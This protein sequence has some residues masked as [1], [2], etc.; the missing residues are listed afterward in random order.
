[1]TAL[2]AS[3]RRLLMWAVPIGVLAVVLATEL[4]WGRDAQRAPPPETPQ[5]PAPVSVG[6]LP[7]YAIAGG[8]AALSTTSEHTLFNPTRRPAPPAVATAS[9]GP[10]QM[11]RGQFI[12]TGTAVYGNTAVAYLKEAAGGKPRSVHKGDTINGMLVAQVD[13][14]GV[15]FTKGGE[16]EDLPLKIAA[17]PKTT[18][19]PAATTATPR[20]PGGG[21]NPVNA[22]G[23]QRQGAQQPNPA[24]GT[25]PGSLG[26]RRR[27]ARAAEAERQRAEPA[28]DAAAQQGN[29]PAAQQPATAAGANG[30]DPS[31]QQMYQR[32]RNRA[33]QK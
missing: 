6:L 24:D 16:S 8:P 23:Q 9:G 17:G 15:R 12:L 1:M 5:A 18:V 11:Q 31:W 20:A 28:K 2:D 27:A 3:T 4:G 7:E 30:Q 10:T 33:N 32:L 26:E 22:R 13:S 14:N 21:G 29:A 25:P 19:Q